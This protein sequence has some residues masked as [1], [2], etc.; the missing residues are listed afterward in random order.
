M[1]II[2]DH[3]NVPRLYH[4]QRHQAKKAISLNLADYQQIHRK[5]NWTIP[6]V[7]IRDSERLSEKFWWLE[8]TQ[9]I[10]DLKERLNR[11][12]LEELTNM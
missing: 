4:K 7:D 10:I 6:D 8:N 3:L 5:Y 9:V 12:K 2:Q 1:G 11:L